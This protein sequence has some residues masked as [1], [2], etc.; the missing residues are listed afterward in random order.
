MRTLLRAAVL[1]ASAW[2][3]PAAN[4][5]ATVILVRHAE[6]AG[7]MAGEE[8][9]SAVG[10]CRAEALAKVLADAGVKRVFTSEVARTRETAEPLARMIGIR[11]EIVPAKDVD[12]L[13]AKLRAGG[14]GDVALVVGHSNTVPQIVER[15]GAGKAPAIGDDE[16]DRMFVVTLTGT[17]QASLLALRY[18]GCAK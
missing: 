6:R 8:G 12:Q 18:A 17:K 14:P 1:L 3:M 5:A 15:L 7:T 13:V 4:P 16:Y 2:T 10:R 9:I 11:P